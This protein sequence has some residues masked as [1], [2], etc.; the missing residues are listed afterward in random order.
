METSLYKH[1]STALVTCL[2]T[3]IP[4]MHIQAAPVDVSD[5]PLY[6][7][8]GVD[9]NIILTLDDS[10][11]MYWSFM[12]DG[13]SGKKNTKRAKSYVY[14]KMYYN[15]NVTYTPPVDHDGNSL[16][17]ASFTSAW[18][19]G[20]NQGNTCTVNLSN[21]YRPTWY[22][23]NHCDSYNSSNEY[24]H[25]S[26]EAAYYYLFDSTNNNCN[27]Q[28]TDDDCYDKVVVSSTSGPGGTDE[29]TNFANWYS[30]YRKR[31]Y[32]MKAAA[33]R[34]FANLSD[35]FRL[36]MQLINDSSSNAVSQATK[37]AGT[38][39]TNFYNWL[40]NV[41]A[42][43]NTPLRRAVYRAGEYLSTAEPYRDD[44]ADAST[45]ERECRQNFLVLMTDG[46]WNSAAG[47]S[48][49]RDNQSHTLPNN[50]MNITSYTPAAPYKDNNS[51]YLADNTFYYWYRDLRPSL[52]NKVPPHIVDSSTDINNDGSVDD[53]DQF[54]N[55][56]NDPAEWQHMVTY[57]IGLGV[58][59]NLSYPAD[60][61]D[62]LTGVKSWSSNQVDDL[63]H[64]AINSRGKYFAADDADTLVQ[65]FTDVIQNIIDRTGSSAPV[66]L[67]MGSITSNTMLYQARFE[68]SGWAG[69]LIASKVSD[70]S[71]CGSVP[72]GDICSP[73]WDAACLLDGGVC[74]A[75]GVSYTPKS[76]DLR[77]I[78]TVDNANGSGIGFR[79]SQLSSTQQ[80][81]LKDPDGPLGPLPNSSDQY[82][83]DRL[84]F[85]RGD[86]TNIA[87]NGGGFRNRTSKLGDIIYSNP[88]YVG[89]PSRYYQSSSSF[90]EASSYPTFKTAYS[91]RDEMV[92]VG[93]ND[94]M[95]HAF[96]AISGDEKFAFIPS[97]V[98][99]N[100]WRLS[101]TDYSHT[102][103]VDGPIAEG[104][105]F[106]NND[107]HTVLVGGLGLGGQGFYALDITDPSSF[108]EANAANMV[109]WEFTDADDPDLGNSF[110]KPAIVR[111][112]D[113]SWAAVFGNGFNNTEGNDG[114]VS[115]TGNAVV[116]IVDIATGNVIK[117][118]D[119]NTG[120][121]NDPTGNSRP[122]GIVDVRP[123]DLDGDS[124][125]D[126]LYAGDLFGNMWVWDLSSSNKSQWAAAYGNGVPLFTAV[127]DSGD[128]QPITT[129]PQVDLHPLGMG[130]M[131]YFGTG[132]YYGTGDLVDTS[133]QS[134]YGIWDAI[135]SVNNITPKIG[136]QRNQ[137]LK[138]EII[139]VNLT[140]F[141]GYDA[142]IVSD[143]PIRWD[144]YSSPTDSD[145]V[146]GWYM[147]LP[148]SG[149]RVHQ[150]PI[151]RNGNIIF[152]TATPSD[153]PCESG[154]T[155]WLMEVD[156]AS[157]GRLQTTP[158]DYNNDGVFSIDDYVQASVDINGDGSIDSGDVAPGSGIRIDNAG[159]YT[160]PAVVL[161]PDNVSE[162][163]IM[164]TSTGAIESVRENSGLNQV[165]SWR[166]LR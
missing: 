98:F 114:N 97:E 154:G 166:E 111:L 143:Y 101:L 26:T 158:F 91:G 100:L 102:N 131:V 90:L 85:L 18:N 64:A 79:W 122:N 95:L 3:A 73:E 32:A 41:D 163:K 152:V 65:S 165:R 136:A 129:A 92:Y 5:A 68:T 117:K 19:D 119:T 146:L 15:P 20:Y 48:G 115:A 75:N 99:S 35:D 8:Q 49:N 88:T 62:L 142:R 71:N 38:Q 132:K 139:T 6:V 127:N 61:A 82:G 25:N 60:Y 28:T 53:F 133:T 55:P 138:Q 86:D 105:V 103:Y 30:Y 151:I 70:G 140:Q 106:Y 33:S 44:P 52:D 13:I 22:Y 126:R 50:S 24:A 29:T 94:G 1:F 21:H 4:V 87:A 58:N 104:D 14:N 124:I 116:F 110:G 31:I 109:L 57:T 120:K 149:E 47:V 96:D 40:F 89:A 160:T 80:D 59:G 130:V 17:D 144:D 108:S 134:F 137:L 145:E 159:I 128:A 74:A 135:N 150:T 84:D 121:S 161:H 123:V 157:G 11:S 113:G 78:I 56:I 45:P 153:D 147:D 37:F 125:T 9:P 107:W 10:G 93:A 67:N 2:L 155:S 42:T 63:W 162:D 112:N 118:L 77:H 156:A 36:S 51:S 46:Y 66:S 141:A 69:H 7:M 72:I 23:G 34:S 43:G 54:W 12:P 164:S 16:G 76:P 27:G 81:M 148:E 39:R 83:M